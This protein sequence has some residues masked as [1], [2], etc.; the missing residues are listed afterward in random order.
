MNPSQWPTVPVVPSPDEPPLYAPIAP[1]PK[2]RGARRSG[3]LGLS[4]GT[5]AG[6]A[7]FF[8]LVT[9]TQVG[10]GSS[11]RNGSYTGVDLLTQPSVY[12][13]G[14]LFWLGVIV[15][16]LGV[17][18]GAFVVAALRPALPRFALYLRTIAVSG[19]TI[20]LVGALSLTLI[21][22]TIVGNVSYGM[23]FFVLL[24]GGTIGALAL[25]S[26]L[27]ESTLPTDMRGESKEY[28]LGFWAGASGVF[29]TGGAFLYPEFPFFALLVVTAPF[30]RAHLQ[31][32][33]LAG[34]VA[35][36]LAALLFFAI[37]GG[38]QVER[39]NRTTP[40]SPATLFMG[41][42]G[43]AL[44]YGIVLYTILIAGYLLLPSISHLGR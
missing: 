10:C 27:W 17:G 6:V 41:R 42:L 16:P 12:F 14:W 22:R 2:I 11:L 7:S 8:T 33:S 38:H 25:L 24:L 19:L 4:G 15:A 28:Q 20:F 44:G 26:L 3:I 13:P 9:V 32:Y 23:A 34:F 18:L 30:S 5:L 43:R 35:L 37:V 21:V 39:V 1:Q 36:A 29:L 40:L 31:D